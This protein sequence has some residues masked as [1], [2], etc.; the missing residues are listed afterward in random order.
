MVG[1]VVGDEKYAWLIWKIL[2]RF[3]KMALGNVGYESLRG[4]LLGILYLYLGYDHTTL[5]SNGWMGGSRLWGR[6]SAKLYCFHS[7]C[8]LVLGMV[9]RCWPV[10]S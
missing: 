3:S 7:H 10:S 1:H 8:N 2:V 9:I 4:L 6:F 5:V